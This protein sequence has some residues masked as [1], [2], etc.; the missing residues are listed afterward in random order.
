MLKE[1][2]IVVLVE[3]DPLH[4]LEAGDIGTIVHVYAD[5]EAFE[6][7]FVT[8]SGATAALVTLKPQKVRA[9]S[10]NEIAHARELST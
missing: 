3:N 8:F 6:V 9:V 4:G 5:G 7:E 1:H 10:S 2:D